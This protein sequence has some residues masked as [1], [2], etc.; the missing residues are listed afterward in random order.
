MRPACARPSLP[1][2]PAAVSSSISRSSTARIWSASIGANEPSSRRTYLRPSAR[3]R[4]SSSRS[5]PTPSLSKLSFSVEPVHPARDL[6]ER[7][8]RRRADLRV[9][10]VVGDEEVPGVGE[11][12]E[13]LRP[14]A[15]RG[16]SLRGE[17]L[18][19]LVGAQAQLL[20]L[21]GGLLL[22]GDVDADAAGA[23]R[24]LLG[25]L[26]DDG[27]GDPVGADRHLQVAVGREEGHLGAHERAARAHAEGGDEVDD[28]RDLGQ[29][30][31]LRADLQRD[32]WEA[33]HD[34]HG[35]L[36]HRLADG[37]GAQQPAHG[38]G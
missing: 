10:E 29:I 30:R 13:A 35:Q 26:H 24:A 33:L 6:R 17:H 19:G 11:G 7:A 8:D 23:L 32:S 5:T 1:P 9:D 34:E 22:S 28:V 38:R 2:L 27:E 36:A 16:V 20:E 4:R 3:Q 14:E 31:Q 25:G 37:R 15:D 18:A 12:G 21:G